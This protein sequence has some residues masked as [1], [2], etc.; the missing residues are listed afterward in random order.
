MT[1]YRAMKCPCGFASCNSWLV[2]PVAAVQCVS[3]TR[4][5]AETVAELLNRMEAG[6][7]NPLKRSARPNEKAA[8]LLKGWRRVRAV[9]EIPVS[10][11]FTNKDWVWLLMRAI[12]SGT[13]LRDF[14][15]KDIR[16]LF[17]KVEIKEF[18]RVMSAEI[19]KL[20]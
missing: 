10:G 20:E 5:Q 17:G 12:T 13:I 1:H 15:H 11:D 3:F 19:K 7:R 14:R 8:R 18:D 2:D 9:V 16:P 6:D 4:E